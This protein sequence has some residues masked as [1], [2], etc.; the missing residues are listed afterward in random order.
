MFLCE[1][2]VRHSSDKRGY[3]HVTGM[4]YNIEARRGDLPGRYTTD[5]AGL[6]GGYLSIMSSLRGIGAFED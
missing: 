6:L 4:I 5:K 3:P 2:F 1:R